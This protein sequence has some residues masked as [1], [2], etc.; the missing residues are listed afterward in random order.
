MEIVEQI[1]EYPYSTISF[2]G[3][4]GGINITMICGIKGGI[5]LWHRLWNKKTK[6][7]WNKLWNRLTPV[8][9]E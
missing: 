1:V 7:L 9:V 4:K 3:I 6:D 8:I 2:C 5:Q